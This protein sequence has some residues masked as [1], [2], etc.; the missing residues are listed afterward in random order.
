MNQAIIPGGTRRES[1]LLVAILAAGA[2]L[3][4]HDLSS[5][6]LWLDEA[7]SWQ[8][9]QFPW[10]EIL[11]HTTEDVHPPLYYFLLKGWIALVGDSVF[12][13]RFLSSLLSLLQLVILFAFC[14]DLTETSC[15]ESGGGRAASGVALLATALAALS[16]FELEYAREVRMYPLGGLLAVSSSWL[17]WRA[18]HRATP[19]F[20]LWAAYSLSAIALTYTHNYGLFTVAGH[21]LFVAALTIWRGRRGPSAVRLRE[22]GV[23]LAVVALAYTAWLPVLLRQRDRVV[24]DYWIPR[25]SVGTVS[26]VVEQVFAGGWYLKPAVAGIA[27]PSVAVAV[28]VLFVIGGR[29][30]DAYV[31]LLASAPFLMALAVSAVQGRNIVHHKYLYFSFPFFLIAVAGV[32]NRIPAKAARWAFALLLVGNLTFQDWIAWRDTDA[33]HKPGIRAAA[34]RVAAE[35][36]EGDLVVALDLSGFLAARYYL[37]HRVPLFYVPDGDSGRKHEGKAVISERDC[38]TARDLNG[39]RGG[40]AWVIA[41]DIAGA[42]VVYIPDRWKYLWDWAIA[43]AS[44]HR[45]TVRLH[46]FEAGEDSRA[47]V[48]L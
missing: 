16:V 6:T 41:T 48:P 39:R 33:A 46:L 4:F 32:I 12:A 8:M 31:A 10:D 30:R 17:L 20:R 28:L 26:G 25:L 34:A 7:F 19:S 15:A 47:G 18:L 42:K 9:V 38:L 22:A 29:L 21:G 23:A 14:K 24:D 35:Y 1:A 44:P 45:G 3:R 11:R 2:F 13:M 27:A 40:R 5:Q 43:D 36:R 37:G